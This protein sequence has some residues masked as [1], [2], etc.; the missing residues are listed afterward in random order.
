[1]EENWIWITEELSRFRRLHYGLWIFF[2][3]KTGLTG[4]IKVGYPENAVCF[5]DGVNQLFKEIPTQVKN[6][7]KFS[8]YLANLWSTRNV[9]IYRVPLRYN[10]VIICETYTLRFYFSIHFIFV[11]F[12]IM[13]SRLYTETYTCANFEGSGSSGNTL[14]FQ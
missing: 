5:V 14:E 13:F 2:F 4:W 7:K 6:S 8:A 10:C 1:M 12:F 9:L 11:K 3:F